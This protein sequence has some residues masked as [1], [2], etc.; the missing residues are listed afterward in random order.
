MSRLISN[1]LTFSRSGDKEE[2]ARHE[3][4]PLSECVERT[5]APFRPSLKRKGIEVSTKIDPG[6]QVLADPDMTAQVLA[7]LVSNV[8]KYAPDGGRLNITNE[9]GRDGSVYLRIADGGP[10]IPV[11]ARERIFEP[12]VRLSERVDEGVSGTGLG[13]AI[14]RD[15]A[16]QMGGELALANSEVGAAFLLQLPS[17]PQNLVVMEERKIS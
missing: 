16:T 3:V 4:F 6:L 10:G 17:P 11:S 7:N 15:L 9:D 8:E 12:F 1:V 5:L 13:L 14:A 2:K